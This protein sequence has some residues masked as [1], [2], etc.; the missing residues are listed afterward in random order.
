MRWRWR[1]NMRWRAIDLLYLFIY[2]CL[3]N[4]A[5]YCYY[6][7]YYYYYFSAVHFVL[8][9]HPSL[10]YVR[11]QSRKIT[12]CALCTR[13]KHSSDMMPFFNPKW[14]Q[15]WHVRA[16]KTQISLRIRVFW[17]KSSLSTWRTLIPRLS[18]MRPVKNLI[19]LHRGAQG[20][21]YLRWARMSEGSLLKCGSNY[22]WSYRRNNINTEQS[23]PEAQRK[24]EIG[25]KEWQDTTKNLYI[26]IYNRSP[27]T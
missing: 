12:I 6:Y 18:Q 10:H 17:S 20:D 7:Y 11:I 27:V 1:E 23:I 21:L 14:A 13:F 9:A 8:S 16:T 15:V 22:K 25:N 26:S 4:N 5:L 2:F 19:R 3:T 24:E